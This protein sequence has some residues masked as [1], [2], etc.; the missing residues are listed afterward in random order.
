MPAEHAHFVKRS[1]EQLMTAV[2]KGDGDAM[3]VLFDRHHRGVHALCVRL[4]HDTDLADDI[5]QE[6]FL[7]VWRYARTFHG[8][9]MFRTWLYRLTYNA[10]IDLRVRNGREHAPLSLETAAHSSPPDECGNRHVILE[11]ALSRLT[12]EH[13]AVL[14]LSRFHDLGYDEIGRIIDCSPGAARV[15]LHR[16]MNELRQLYFAVEEKCV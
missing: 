13:R 3:G 2:Q 12:P 1:D 6:V 16:A 15:R 4:S 7:R 9:S 5:A 8:R 14:V 10:C 11:I